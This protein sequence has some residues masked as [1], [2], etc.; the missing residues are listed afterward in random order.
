MN[1]VMIF[2]QIQSGMGTKDD[3]M[4]PLA[5]KKVAIGPAVMMEKDLKEIDAQIQACLY[6]GTAFYQQNP[7]EVT[8]KFCAMI[9]KL[10]PDVVICGPAYDYKNYATM[11]ASVAK[12]ITLTNVPVVVAMAKENIDVIAQYK[13]ELSIVITPEKGGVGLH[14]ALHNICALAKQ[15]VDGKIDVDFVKQIC[16]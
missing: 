5:G 8:R 4:L 10:Q 1:V 2:D 14:Q 15:M 7:Q 16:F 6:C 13:D 12:A 3:A 9:A 11:C